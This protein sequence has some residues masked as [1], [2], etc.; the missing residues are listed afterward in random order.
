[1]RVTGF[2][3]ETQLYGQQLGAAVNHQPRDLPQGGLEAAKV[4]QPHRVTAQPSHTMLWGPIR[5]TRRPSS[6]INVL[7]MSLSPHGTEATE[8]TRMLG[9]SWGSSGQDPH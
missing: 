7:T 5:C 3:R 1:M 4:Y 6:Y 8:G 2:S 9:E